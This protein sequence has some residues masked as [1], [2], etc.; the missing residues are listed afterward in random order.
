M[1]AGCPVFEAFEPRLLLTAFV[2][3]SAADSGPGTLREAI[4]SANTSGG[5]DTIS[6]NIG[7]GG[8]HTISLLSNLPAIAA[9]DGAVILDATTQPG[10]AGSPLIAINGGG[11]AGNGLILF[12]GNS[13][14]KGLA[15]QNFASR[16]IFIGLNGGNTIE[17]NYIGTDLTGNIDMGNGLDGILVNGVSGNVIQNNVISGNNDEGIEF[18]L[19]ATGNVVQNNKIGTNAAGTADLGNTNTGITFNAA[20]NDNNQVLNNLISGNDSTAI[21]IGSNNI[22]IRGNKIGTDITGTLAIANSE[23]GIQ[24]ASGASNNT[25]GGQ[26]AGQGN[27][28]AFNARNG[29]RVLTGT[30]NRIS[31]NSIFSNGTLGIDLIPVVAGVTPND[32]LDLDSGPNGLQNFPVILTAGSDGVV[33][34]ITGTISS[35][36]NTNL[37]IEFFSSPSP[38]PSGFGEGKTYLGSITVNTGVTGTVPFIASVAASPVGSVIT[39]TATTA[40][41]DT[42]EFSGDAVFPPLVV[43]LNVAPVADAGGPYVVAEGGTVVLDASGSTDANQ[44][45]ASLTYEWDFDGDSFFDDAVGMNPVFSAAGLDGFV[46]ST[47]TVAVRVTDNGSLVS[48]DTATISITNV[49]PVLSNVAV[50]NGDEGGSVTLTG[51]ITDPGTPDAFTLTIDW[52]NGVEVLNFGPGTTS[53]SVNHTY[54][55]DDPTGTPSDNITINLTLQD[56]D[57]G[58]DAG[59]A[60]TTISNV[61]PV[62]APITGPTAAAPGQL[63]TYSSSFTDGGTLDTHTKVW[64]IK[65]SSNVVVASGT[66]LSI[67]F[68]PSTIDTFTITFTVADDD[69]GSDSKSLSLLVT[70]AVLAADPANPG[71]TALFVGG[72]NGNDIIELTKPSNGLVKVVIRNGNTL[73]LVYQGTFSTAGLDR[74]VVSGLAGN[75]LISVASNL[76]ASI[77]AELYGNDGNDLITGGSGDDYIDGGAGI[78]VIF[79]GD[80]RDILVGGL[81]LDIV[82]GNAD[83][84]ILIGGVYTGGRNSLAA[85][86]AEWNSG[87]NYTT[88]VNNLRNG[89]GLNGSFVLNAT[90]V[91]DDAVPDILLG[92]QGRDWFLS[93]LEDDI[94]DKAA[95]EVLTDIEIDF[96]GL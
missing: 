88:R 17:A 24:I 16:G 66:G 8:S 37:T 13:T 47:I 75:D 15:I 49:A 38:D 72:T 1:D 12:A 87:H 43:L 62:V 33:T 9:G 65:N 67:N 32:P 68:T 93:D 35:S 18:N 69:T 79:G 14:I 19:G 52:G 2:V 61:A 86:F 58:S 44:S 74:F 29:V 56:D 59:S 91:F 42:S 45:T 27:T 76:P 20:G 90:T 4:L 60:V 85:L 64:T 84:D 70:G 28:I 10:Y 53:F 7:G 54:V 40:A 94:T 71:D 57:G 5:A 46:G 23:D 82:T 80:G 78:D 51:N 21:L 83:D 95:N 36:I 34:L 48:T 77:Q 81:G 25:I 55:D 6:F 26:L 96:F 50:T 92:L 31:G 63:L 41:G 22:T 30:G 3:T 73:A 39:S 11:G 89:G